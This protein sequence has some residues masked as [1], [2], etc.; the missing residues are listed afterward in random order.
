[1]IIARASLNRRTGAP[2]VE[3]AVQGPL[4][5]QSIPRDGTADRDR[6]ARAMPVLPG[7]TDGTILPTLPCPLT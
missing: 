7:V 5:K 3:E 1:V 4:A 6:V 2:T